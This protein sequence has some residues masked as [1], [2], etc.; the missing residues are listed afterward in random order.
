MASS[1]TGLAPGPLLASPGADAAILC[2]L[3]VA[4]SRVQASV[5][6][7]ERVAVLALRALLGVMKKRVGGS[8]HGDKVGRV[9]AFFGVAKVVEVPA[10]RDGAN[11]VEVGGLV[12]LHVGATAVKPD[13][14]ILAVAFGALAA[15]DRPA[16]DETF[17][18][19][20]FLLDA[21]ASV[22]KSGL[23]PRSHQPPMGDR[24]A[25]SVPVG[26]VA[27]TVPATFVG[28]LTA[29]DHAAPLAHGESVAWP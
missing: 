7:R 26:V 17:A 24:V 23:D 11:E 28:G 21:D 22:P 1:V 25:R 5:F 12:G 20:A 15:D 6:R 2:R 3:G 29:G 4:R 27:R 16:E 10:V 13:A 18:V 9:P 19:D 14:S 8:A